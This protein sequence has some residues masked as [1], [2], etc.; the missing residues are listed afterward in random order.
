M[1]AA[2]TDPK[3]YFPATSRNREVIAEVL[4]RVLDDATRVLEIASGSG[5]HITH[6]AQR[7]AQSHPQL[8]WQPS[9]IEDE[10]LASIRAW[11]T[12]LG[13]EDQ[14]AAPIR[15]D[16]HAEPWPASALD[17]DAIFCANMIHI[18]P[19]TAWPALLEGAARSLPSGGPLVLYGPFKRDGRHTAPSNEAFD[20]RLKS[21]DPSWGVR[22]LDEIS[23]SA[24]SMGLSLVE[25]V[26]MPAN[27]LT[28]IFRRA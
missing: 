15:L 21:K 23:A 10:H 3:L 26:S 17:C 24:N 2:N 27:N 6:F 8:R 25:A 18:A 28:A 7:F 16:V 12:E 14:V 5:E 22:D 1:T 19:A 9:D 13:L 11:T 4:A 20:A